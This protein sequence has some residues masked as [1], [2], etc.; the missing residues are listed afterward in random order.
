MKHD[1]KKC[2]FCG[3]EWEPRVAEP[4]QCPRC[5]RVLPESIGGVKNGGVQR[6]AERETGSEAEAVLAVPSGTP[7]AGR[8][9]RR[10]V[11]AVG[12]EPEI[13]TP[14]CP[15]DGD[16]MTWNRTMKWWECECS[17][18]TNGENHVATKV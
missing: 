3:S 15:E 16:L 12:S 4:V 17:Y 8:N 7:D 5:K 9:L 18:H 10:T 1:R 11:E 14:R 6:K 13:T 2:P